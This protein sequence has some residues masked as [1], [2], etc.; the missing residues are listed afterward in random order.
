[1][2]KDTLDSEIR[3]QESINDNGDGGWCNGRKK[4]MLRSKKF[5]LDMG[6]LVLE[7]RLERNG[8][9]LWELSSN[10]NKIVYCLT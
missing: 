10:T 3:A 2:R 4:V 7:E 1:M 6:V 8:C 9:L 5:D